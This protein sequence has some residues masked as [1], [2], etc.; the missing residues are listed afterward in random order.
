[1]KKRRFSWLLPIISSK[2]D[3]FS[4]NSSNML[5]NR[6]F[7]LRLPIVVEISKFLLKTIVFSRNRNSPVP[8]ILAKIV[9]NS[10]KT[11]RNRTKQVEFNSIYLSLQVHTKTMCPSWKYQ[12]LY[13]KNFDFRDFRRLCWANMTIFH[14]TLRVCRIIVFSGTDY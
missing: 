14:K 6:I 13:Q 5:N 4:Q 11:H 3:K 12:V 1:M 8:E 2:S 7:W 10:L 9:D